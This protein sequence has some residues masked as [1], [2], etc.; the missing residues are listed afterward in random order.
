MRNRHETYCFGWMQV[1]VSVSNLIA[2]YSEAD[3]DIGRGRD[4]SIAS[5]KAW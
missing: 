5:L 1:F 4:L 2:E 3:H